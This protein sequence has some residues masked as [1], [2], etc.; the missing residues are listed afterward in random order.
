VEAP[1]LDTVNS[2]EVATASNGRANKSGTFNVKVGNLDKGAETVLLKPPKGVP[3]VP[4]ASARTRAVSTGTARVSTRE[5]RFLTTIF[6]TLQPSGRFSAAGVTTKL[7]P[8][9]VE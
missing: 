4:S 8:P 7:L 3:V 1:E 2:G 6:R 5:F 9:R